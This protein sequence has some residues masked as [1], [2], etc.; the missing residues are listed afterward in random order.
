MLANGNHNAI[1]AQTKSSKLKDTFLS[2][3]IRED[4]IMDG[5]YDPLPSWASV[6]CSLVSQD[7]ET[8]SSSL[9]FISGLCLGFLIVPKPLCFSPILCSIPGL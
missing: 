5:H 8:S 1:S 2:F 7:H 9:L 3:K 4:D 6:S